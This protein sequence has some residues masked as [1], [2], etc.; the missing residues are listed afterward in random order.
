M[1]IET[2]VEFAC[3]YCKETIEKVENCVIAEKNLKSS[4]VKE[5]KIKVED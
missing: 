5:E 2:D 3:P 1:Y 4:V